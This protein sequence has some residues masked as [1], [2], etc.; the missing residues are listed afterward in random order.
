MKLCCKILLG[1]GSKPHPSYIFYF[2]WIK[3]ADLTYEFEKVDKIDYFE[4]KRHTDSHLVAL[5]QM[6]LQMW[7]FS[8]FTWYRKKTTSFVILT[9]PVEDKIVKTN[10]LND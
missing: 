4:K 3:T 5:W 2:Q 1:L 9:S 8:S 7:H 6:L 10:S